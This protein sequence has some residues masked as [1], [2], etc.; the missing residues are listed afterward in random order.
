M[1]FT[2]STN[3]N[4]EHYY[5][6]DAL[7]LLL[8]KR[9][10]KTEVQK[11]CFWDREAPSH[12]VLKHWIDI[13]EQKKWT[14][15]T[16][17]MT[18]Y[19]KPLHSTSNRLQ[20]GAQLQN[21][22]SCSMSACWSQGGSPIKQ[23][24]KSKNIPWRGLDNRLSGQKVGWCNSGGGEM[25]DYWWQRLTGRRWSGGRS[26]QKQGTFDQRQD[27]RNTVLMD[28]SSTPSSWNKTNFAAAQSSGGL[29]W[30]GAEVSVFVE[31]LLTLES[32][33]QMCCAITASGR[34][35]DSS[36]GLGAKGHLVEVQSLQY[37][38]KTPTEV[39]AMDTM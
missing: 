4:I 17:I 16:V 31:F 15:A 11:T 6:T 9:H 10:A 37:V 13:I 19:L 1:H 18:C 35:R 28:L 8:S 12:T 5:Q 27:R 14:R 2:C 7:S 26:K 21:R 3:V 20:P 38:L 29:P 36:R 22:P 24:P 39:S 30:L 25:S 34:R 32:E 23:N 33:R